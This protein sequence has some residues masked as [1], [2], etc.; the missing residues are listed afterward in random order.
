MNQ[1]YFYNSIDDNMLSTFYY[2]I[3]QKL[4]SGTHSEKIF[5]DLKMIE[6]VAYIRD[7]QMIELFEKGKKFAENNFLYDS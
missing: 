1:R 6:D 7:L 4:M 3:L 5:E 2:L